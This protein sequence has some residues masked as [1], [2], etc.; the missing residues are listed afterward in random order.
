VA[1]GPFV[2]LDRDGTLIVEKNYLSDP[3][4][5]E[6]IP[7]APQALLRLRCGGWGVAVV[8]NQSGVARGFFTAADVDGIHRRVLE[9]LGEAAAAVSAF[10][11]C[12][13]APGQGCRCRKPAT[14][15]V[16]QAAADL[17][18]DPRQAWVVGDKTV[19]IEL[20]RNCGARTILVRTG[21]GARIEAAAARPDH[22]VPDLPAAVELILAAGPA[23]PR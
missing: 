15:M 17:G 4:Q 3:S 1:A 14:G 21:Y 20:G 19:D 8:S 22:S 11:Y 23:T 2:L 9:L 6:L 12:P 7:G 10:Y 16:E 18:F 5:V 13:H